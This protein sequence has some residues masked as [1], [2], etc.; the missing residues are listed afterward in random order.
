M[1]EADT[2]DSVKSD[3]KLDEDVRNNFIAWASRINTRDIFLEKKENS[4]YGFGLNNVYVSHCYSCKQYSLWRADILIYPKANFEIQPNDD[5]DQSIKDDFIEAGSVIDISPRAASALLRLA[6][7]K[8]LRQLGEKGDN[9]ND[10]IGELVKKGLDPK[11]Q[12]A[13][14]LV[15]VVGNNSVHPGTLDMRDN[16]ETAIR[17]FGLIN[18]IAYDRITHPREVSAL[19]E[20]HLTDGQKSAVSR[21]DGK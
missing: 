16:R 8:L 9:I 1:V 3:L 15:R 7:Q 17:L 14:D 21:R 5:L 10:D 2:I 4:T 12:Q 20:S 6:L 18:L 13:L 19:Y 11:I